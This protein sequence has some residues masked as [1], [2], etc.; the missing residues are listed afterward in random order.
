[1]ASAAAPRP[2]SREGSGHHPVLCPDQVTTAHASPRASVDVQAT[3]RLAKP[4]PCPGLGRLLC[5]VAVGPRLGQASRYHLVASVMI[6]VAASIH[7][8]HAGPSLTYSFQRT[9]N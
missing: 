8:E 7:G 3:G 5:S 1:M 6:M 9:P 4:F 2:L